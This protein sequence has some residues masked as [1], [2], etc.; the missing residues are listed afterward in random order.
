MTRCGEIGTLVLCQWES[1]AVKLL[2]KMIT[3]I[4]QKV[5]NRVTIPYDPPF[6]PLGLYSKELKAASS[7][8]FVPHVYSSII[9]SSR[10]GKATQVSLDSC[11][12][13]Q[14]IYR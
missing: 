8:D 13:K 7:R 4:P 3:V 12:D 14:N 5:K 10:K 11:I 6:P 1:A 2:W 9:H